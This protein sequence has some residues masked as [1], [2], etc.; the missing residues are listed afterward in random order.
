LKALLGPVL[1]FVSALFAGSAHASTITLEV[2]DEDNVYQ[3]GE[4]VSIGL[5]YDFVDDNTAAGSLSADY[6]SSLLSF[7]SFAFSPFYAPTYENPDDT[8]LDFNI[9]AT[10]NN[11]S[12]SG[13]DASDIFFGRIGGLQWAE[14]ID[15][16]VVVHD[17]RQGM[18]GVFYY[19][20]SQA[21]DA[22]FTLDSLGSGF[23]NNTNNS[24][25][26]SMSGVSIHVA[27]VPEMETWLMM[28]AGMGVLGWRL[29]KTQ[30]SV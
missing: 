30:I 20:A 11:P 5:F 18:V 1:F 3:I 25:F 24:S 9:I 29:R 27:P 14:F 4:T 10:F 2:M 21:G 19:E 6:D 7:S 26:P 16:E 8:A 17:E 13:G 22:A 28:L 15:S 23:Y 12:V